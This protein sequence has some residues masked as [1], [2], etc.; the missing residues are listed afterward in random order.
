MT[1]WQLIIN[2]NWYPANI[3]SRIFFFNFIQFCLRQI[4]RQV[5]FAHQL[6][7]CFF[8]L[9]GIFPVLPASAYPVLTHF[10]QIMQVMAKINNLCIAACTDH[11]DIFTGNMRPAQQHIVQI[12]AICTDPVLPVM[13]IIITVAYFYSHLL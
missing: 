8:P 13:E 2:K 4:I 5:C 9:P 3:D 11:I 6:L 10:A 1:F 12:P 7:F